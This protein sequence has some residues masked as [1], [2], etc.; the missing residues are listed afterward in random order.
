MVAL[1]LFLTANGSH[2][3]SIL[4]ISIVW[5]LILISYFTTIYFLRSKYLNRLLHMTEQLE[6]QYLI[7]EVMTLPEKADEQVYYLIPKMAEKSMLEKIGE[8]Q[9]ERK[10]YKESILPLL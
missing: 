10:E 7:P 3:Q 6:E 4:S 1:A 2:I 5:L 9:R 8:I